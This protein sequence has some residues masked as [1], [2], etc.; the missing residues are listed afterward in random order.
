MR[1][2]AAAAR[3]RTLVLDEIDAVIGGRAGEAVG[4]KLQRLARHYQVLCVTHLASIASFADHHIQVE[5]ETSGGRTRTQA[6]TLTG[7]ARVAELARMLAGEESGAEALRHA[8][9]LLERNRAGGAA[10]HQ[11]SSR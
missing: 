6:M 5:K 2:G 7:E 11:T 3:G 4:R 8:R 1:T 10:K 9:A